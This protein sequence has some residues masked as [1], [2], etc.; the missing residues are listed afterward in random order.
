MFYM[1]FMLGTAAY[2]KQEER[3]LFAL[4]EDPNYNINQFLTLSSSDIHWPELYRMIDSVLVNAEGF[5]TREVTDVERRKML[6]ANPVLASIHFYNR[7]QSYLDTILL[8]KNE[9]HEYGFSVDEW[10]IRMECQARGKMKGSHVCQ[11]FSQFY[12]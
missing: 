10:W 11:C 1:V 6:A 8:Y 4:A 7:L 2:F 12:V 9:F 3:N 5:F